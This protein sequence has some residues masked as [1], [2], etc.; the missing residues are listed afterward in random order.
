MGG[1]IAFLVIAAIF[2]APVLI[3]RWRGNVAATPVEVAT[4]LAPS[5]VLAAAALAAQDAVTRKVKKGAATTGVHQGP[6]GTLTF[7]VEVPKA[8]V[9]SVEVTPS[10][11]GSTVILAGTDFRTA[12][13]FSLERAAR[14]SS[15][16][17]TISHRLTAFWVGIFDV[18]ANPGK[19]TRAKRRI[20]KELG[21]AA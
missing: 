6:N 14:A 15:V 20:A 17:T 1:F 18:P 10:G 16:I 3:G 7:G 8:G 21:R 19:V 13:E 2:V 4:H 9:V 11:S 12:R 5:S